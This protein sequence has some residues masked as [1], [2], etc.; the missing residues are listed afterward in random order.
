MLFTSSLHF[1]DGDRVIHTRLLYYSP[2][3]LAFKRTINFML[4]IPTPLFLAS[5]DV[6]SLCCVGNVGFYW[7]KVNGYMG[8]VQCKTDA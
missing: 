8:N 7:R 6:N 5:G 1:K 2:L 4:N 3:L